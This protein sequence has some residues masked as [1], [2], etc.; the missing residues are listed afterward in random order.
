MPWHVIA[1]SGAETFDEVNDVAPVA[2]TYAPLYGSAVPPA[3][4][5]ANASSVPLVGWFC[6]TALIVVAMRR[7]SALPPP[8]G[9]SGCVLWLLLLARQPAIVSPRI[10]IKIVLRIVRFSSCSRV[11]SE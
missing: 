11:G 9:A 10:M 4:R 8:G 2:W 1:Y 3:A 5:F 7:A 6:R